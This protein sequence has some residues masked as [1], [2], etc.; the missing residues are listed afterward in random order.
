MG[1]KWAEDIQCWSGYEVN[2][3][4]CKVGPDSYCISKIG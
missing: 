4:G 3:D 2:R 1:T